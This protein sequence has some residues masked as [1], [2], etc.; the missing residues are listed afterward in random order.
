[1][2]VYNDQVSQY[3]TRIF[4]GEDEALQL[5]REDSLRLGLPGISI[6]PEEGR[7]LQFLVRACGVR[8]ALELGT[9]GGYS[10]IWIARGLLP[11]GRLIS[12]DKDLKHADVARAHFA[13]AGLDDRVEVRV[14]EAGALLPLLSHEGPFDFVFID[15]D[16]PGY[17]LYFEWAVEN[18]RPGG[19]I[20]AHNAFRRGSVT[21]QAP[22]DEFTPIMRAFNARLASDPRLISTIYPAGDGTLLS[23]KI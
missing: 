11:G 3:I 21:G 14:G 5:A 8:L 20:A 13:A 2:T 17:P 6:K 15:A 7:F 23:V 4:A 18:T 1:M 12:I 16:K 19:V 22:E 9:L 10:G